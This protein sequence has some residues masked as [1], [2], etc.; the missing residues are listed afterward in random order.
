MLQL[1]IPGVKQ[2]SRERSN[3][4]RLVRSKRLIMEGAH[5][6]ASARG[7]EMEMNMHV[8]TNEPA[9]TFVSIRRLG[10]VLLASTLVLALFAGCGVR[11]DQTTGQSL[12]PTDAS[13]ALAS[14]PVTLQ[15]E[16][17]VA[18]PR[19]TATPNQFVASP[20]ASAPA[21]S[22]ASS[23]CRS[24][25]LDLETGPLVS[26]PTGQ[27]TIS[28]TLTNRS[29]HACSL[30][31]YPRVMLLA[32]SGQV[33]PFDFRHQGDQVV[34][35]AAPQQIELTPGAVAYVTLN[36]YRC[37]LGDQ[38]LVS[39]LQLLLPGDQTTLGLSLP[40][41]SGVFGFCGPGDPGSIVSIS[42]LAATFGATLSH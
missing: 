6:I 24:P 40:A 26:E 37:D 29:S 22:S 4:Y 21:T 38:A 25:D 42:P 2:S 31:G 17:T 34:T 1:Y 32:A 19:S 16:L 28:L 35:S 13:R 18:A 27:H 10:V 8:H 39:S 3:A 15:A 30:I 5:E 7:A 12:V 9:G 33:L 20:V 14:P 36:K 41:E 23:P 11:T